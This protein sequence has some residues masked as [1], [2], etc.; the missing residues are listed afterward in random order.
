M[1]ISYAAVR[2]H[3]ARVTMPSVENGWYTSSNIQKDPPKSISTRRIDKVGDTM[4]TNIMIAESPDRQC[5]AI[6]YYARG[7]NPMVSVNYGQGQSGTQAYLPYTVAR[8]GAFRPPVLYG[9]TNLLPLSRLPRIL[10]SVCAT[11]YQ[12]IF[13]KRIRDCGTVEQTREVKSDLLRVSCEAQKAIQTEPDL[14]EPITAL[15]I[16][17][18]VMYQNVKT[19]PNCPTNAEEIRQRLRQPPIHLMTNRP[20]CSVTTTG[21][22]AIKTGK[23]LIEK[24]DTLVLAPN[25][26]NTYA[27][28]NYSV[29]RESPVVFNNV[30]LEPSRPYTT[31][32]T[33]LVA[34]GTGFSSPQEYRRL[35]SR[36]NLGG[37]AG[38]RQIPKIL[39]NPVKRLTR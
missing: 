4:A 32:T 15:Q 28:T 30:H 37:F 31:A 2:N 27:H 1:A 25:K 36:P 14:N 39:E 11:P 29:H 12:P 18:D 21:A 33:S 22:A 9:V 3:H 24:Y 13:T 5:E 10:T 35:Q 34:P 6:N 17:D 19:Q 38:S 7:V 20:S 26:P 8:D 23:D 16:R